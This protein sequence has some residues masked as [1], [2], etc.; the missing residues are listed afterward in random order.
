MGRYLESGNNRDR[1]RHLHS[2]FTNFGIQIDKD[3]FQDFLAIKYIRNSYIHGTWNEEQRKFALS[4]NFPGDL[5]QFTGEHLAKIKRV[6]QSI[7]SALGTV[8][9]IVNLHASKKT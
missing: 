4:R 2:A 7:L 5:M 3:V 9:A 6:Y 8:N 1:M